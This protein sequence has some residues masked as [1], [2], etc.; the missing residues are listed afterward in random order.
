MPSAGTQ[1]RHR[2]LGQ[3]Q[4]PLAVEAVREK[5]RHRREEELRAQLQGHRDAHGPGVV[6]RQVGEDQPVLGGAL[7]PGADIGDERADKPDPVVQ[8][9]QGFERGHQVQPS[10]CT[11]PDASTR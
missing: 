4:E 11:L 3:H 10:F 8:D 9:V 2:G 7:H 6:R 1:Q 5:S